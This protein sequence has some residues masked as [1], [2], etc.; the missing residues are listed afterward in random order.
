MNTGSAPGP[1]SM[2]PGAGQAALETPGGTMTI[3]SMTSQKIQCRLGSLPNAPGR[4][5]CG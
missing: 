4:R 5:T 2:T 3:R 1:G